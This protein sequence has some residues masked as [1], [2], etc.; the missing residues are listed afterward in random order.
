MNI[1]KKTTSNVILILGV[2]ILGLLITAAQV[3]N[4]FKLK[5][6]S[7]ELHGKIGKIYDDV[8]EKPKILADTEKLKLEILE[9]KG[10]VIHY[11]E[12]SSL[13][14]YISA[15]AK[16]YSLDIAETGSS[17]AQKYKKVGDTSFL[18]VP[19]NVTLRGGYH[20]LGAFIA[21][22]ENGDYSLQVNN[23]NIS[24]GKQNNNITLSILALAIE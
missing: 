4:I 22:I 21:D 15:A 18:Q 13:Q 10:K 8:S 16:K 24:T 23:I 5:K 12:I 1:D 3:K 17:P 7:K 14:A 2:L 6:D 19:I 20:Q 11:Q 9:I